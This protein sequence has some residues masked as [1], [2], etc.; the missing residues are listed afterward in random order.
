MYVRVELDWSGDYCHHSMLGLVQHHTKPTTL[1][2]LIFP[3]LPLQ[4]SAVHIAEFPGLHHYV[5]SLEPS[6]RRDVL[7]AL[8]VLRY[9]VPAPRL[10]T[11]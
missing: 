1:M 2:Q 3:W 4:R 8:I 9:A 11:L 5:S 10:Q 6:K 7:P